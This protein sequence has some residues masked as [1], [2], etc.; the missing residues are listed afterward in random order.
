MQIF[1][2]KATLKQLEDQTQQ[3]C[4]S[5][6]T[7]SARCAS[8][9]GLFET[10]GR[11]LSLTNEIYRNIWV[12]DEARD[13]RETPVV[14]G[15]I[16][17][18]ETSIALATAI[19]GTKDALKHQLMAMREGLACGLSRAGADKAFRRELA[20]IGLGKLSLRQVYRHIATL[21]SRPQS[22]AFS[23][24][25]KGKSVKR[26][27]VSEAIDLLQR[28]GFEGAHIDIQLEILMGLP[29]N[30]M[31]AQVQHLAAYYKANVRFPCGIRETQSVFMP[32]LYPEG[33]HAVSLPI[34]LH[35][36]QRHSRERKDHV[37][38]GA[39]FIPSLR[40]YRYHT[41]KT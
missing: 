12:E 23:Y 18:S 11:A 24:S 35:E 27:L 22:I 2:L 38:E 13:A 40:I 17:A 39:A 5:L 9:P 14:V 20:E 29:D 34:H 26:L 33:P 25:T 1:T 31:L 8:K 6:A 10:G 19:N 21:S 36:A 30:Y 16:E 41:A 28:S 3:L 32:I 15:A 37:L 7:S 4:D